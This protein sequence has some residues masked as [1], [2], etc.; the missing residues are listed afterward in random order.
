MTLRLVLPC[1]PTRFHVAFFRVVSVD[2]PRILQCTSRPSTTRVSKSFEAA[3]RA[4][5]V[6]AGG[7]SFRN[8]TKY[9]SPSASLKGS[10]RRAL[11]SS[12]AV[13][14]NVVTS[15]PNVDSRASSMVRSSA[16][17]P[18]VASKTTLPLLMWVQAPS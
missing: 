12:V 6:A 13:R 7:T 3:S 18:P 5:A 16:A 14:T 10:T 17:R 15:K 11:S 2:R 9:V 4:F 8:V 1:S